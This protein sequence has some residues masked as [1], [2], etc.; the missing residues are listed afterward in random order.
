MVSKRCLI[1]IA[2]FVW[3][4]AG[5]NVLRFG[6]L[7]YLGRAS[8]WLLLWTVIVFVPFFLMFQ[9]MVLKNTARILQLPEGKSL[10]VQF[11]P[12]KSYILIVGMM[13]I[14][15]LLRNWESVPRYFIAFFYTGLG[16]AL[17][18][19]G[20]RYAHQFFRFAQCA[21]QDPPSSP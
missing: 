14:G 3:V 13:S 7:D 12:L 16:A 2:A 15:I 6:I 19:A 11:F 8:I 18:S 5:C 4:V 9:K 1:G 21:F 10:F 17:L 20:I